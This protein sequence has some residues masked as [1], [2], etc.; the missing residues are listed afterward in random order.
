MY[1]SVFFVMTSGFSINIRSFSPSKKYSLIR[2]PRS[3]FLLLIFTFLIHLEFVSWKYEEIKCHFPPHMGSLSSLILNTES[4]LHRDYILREC[5]WLDFSGIF[6]LFVVLILGLLS[7][8]SVYW[9]FRTYSAFH[10]LFCDFSPPHLF[11]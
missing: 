8:C 10:T 9:Y 11:F 2:S 6:L 1:V 3:L 7:C 4:L 5:R